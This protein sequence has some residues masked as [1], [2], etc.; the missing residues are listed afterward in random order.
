M[1][2][3]TIKNI[4]LKNKSR[5]IVKTR[6]TKNPLRSYLKL[7]STTLCNFLFTTGILSVGAG[8]VF[9][10]A[11]AEEAEEV[12]EIEETVVTATRVATPATA[13]PNTITI[14]DR[15]A[16]SEQSIIADD[17]PSI[18]ERKVSGY[19]PSLQKLTGRGESLR[20]RNPLYVIDGIPQHNSLRDG[21]R[22][23]HTIDTD[24]VD[25]IE[26]IHG[27][28]AIQGIGATGGVVS[29]TTMTPAASGK[30]NSRMKIGLTTHDSG[31]SDALGYKGSY[32]GGRKF[33]EGVGVVVGV[34]I[35][36]RGLQNDA[37]KLPVGM[38]GTQ[39]DIMNSRSLDA[40]LK[41][42]YDVRKSQKIQLMVNHFNL[43]KIGDFM[44]LNGDRANGVPTT[45]IATN[46]DIRAR[47]VGDPTE[48]TVTSISLDF[49]HSQLNNGRLVTQLYMNKFSA[50]YEGGEYVNKN[51]GVG[52]FRKTVDGPPFL[53]QSEI[54][55]DKAGAKTVY[56]WD[57]IEHLEPTV[58]LDLAID[59]TRQVLARSGRE[60]VPEMAMMSFAPF[61]QF[62][63]R[64][65]PK[66]RLVGGLRYENARISVDDYVTIAAAGST[67]V[68]GGKPKYDT[69][70]PNVGA[71]IDLHPKTSVHFS[72]A[73]GYTMPDIGRVLRG[74]NGPGQ[75]VDA[76]LALDPIVTKNMEMGVNQRFG[77]VEVQGAYYRS[78][79]DFGALLKLNESNIFEVTR[80]KTEVQGVQLTVDVEV[81]EIM[82]AGLN[83]AWNK[84]EYDSD[85]NGE[86]DTDLDGYNI[87]PDRINIFAELDLKHGVSSLFQI[88]SLLNR[89]FSGNADER[90]IKNGVS[91]TGY[92]TADL[93]LSK[94]TS[95][96]KV[97]LAIANVFDKQYFRY[98]SQIEPNQGNNTYFAGRGR[99]LTLGLQREF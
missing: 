92:T 39:G 7:R 24:F 2:L 56:T 54:Q 64:L 84:G 23:G 77:E 74:I 65:N 75:D 48:N 46:P 76:L 87:A 66:F 28:N 91:F 63:Y 80:Q 6:T 49:S 9:D 44:P 33:D 29:M 36:Q 5:S 8:G 21:Q 98:F 3:N 26:V 60:W 19:G 4:N 88:S 35:N 18:L 43:A 30:W 12:L 42:T 68:S 51:T 11:I 32:A 62:A 22:D 96:G 58:G 70:L 78:N 61:V 52:Y 90:H 86:V 14:L 81:N 38:Y 40:F 83:Y 97:S 50:L 57:G 93:H 71:V 69:V 27:S 59:N 85:Q 20:G 31:D 37:N 25:R 82:T 47:N 67:P 16:I 41:T 55:S 89:D 1:Y 99:T 53:D 10:P 95:L 13:I 72:F 34:A 15:K 45:T 73:E 17:I 94:N 79:A